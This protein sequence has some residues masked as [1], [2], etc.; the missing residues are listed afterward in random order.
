MAL[1]NPYVLWKLILILRKKTFLRPLIRLSPDKNGISSD[2][3]LEVSFLNQRAH[4]PIIVWLPQKLE[5]AAQDWL[6]D[7]LNTVSYKLREF[8]LGVAL[9]LSSYSLQP[10]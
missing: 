10:G 5:I 4:S 3:Y 2:A 8:G 9:A 1:L 6:L 7:M